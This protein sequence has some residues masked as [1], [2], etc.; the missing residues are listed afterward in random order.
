LQSKAFTLP[1]AEAD[2]DGDKRFQSIPCDGCKQGADLIGGEYFNR[3]GLCAWGLYQ[4][5]DVASDEAIAQGVGKGLAND[6][7]KVLDGPAAEVVCF[8]GE[9]LA[10][11]LR[12]ELGELPVSEAGG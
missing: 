1:E 5:G 8:L 3:L 6:S 9:E 7:V 12:I 10:E 4:R 2:G 11:Y